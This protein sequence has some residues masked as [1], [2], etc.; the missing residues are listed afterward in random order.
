MKNKISAFIAA[1]TM[2][3]SSVAAMPHATVDA[4]SSLPSRVDLSETEFYPG[5]MDQGEL[6]SCGPCAAVFGQFTYEVRK[7]LREKDP[8]ADISFTYSP[9]SVYS[10]INLGIN[11]PVFAESMYT[12]LM[13][14]GALTEDVF[15]YD[16]NFDALDHIPNDEKA[17]FDALK[18]RVDR[19]E[20]IELNQMYDRKNNKVVEVEKSESDARVRKGIKDIK[21]ALNEGKVLVAQNNYNFEEYIA[22][23]ATRKNKPFNEKVSYQNDF[24]G[25]SHYFT[26]VGYDDEIACDINGDTR[27]DPDTEK[28]AFKIADS[29]GEDRGNNGYMWVMYD[30]LY[31]ES[32]TG[33][34][35]ISY[36][37]NNY[38]YPALMG[39]YEIY[40]SEKDIKLVAEAD[41]KT[42]NY[43]DVYLKNKCRNNGLKNTSYEKEGVLPVEYEGPV[44][45]DIT[46]ICGDSAN[47][48]TFEVTV[49]N[50]NNY[51]YTKVLVKNICLKDD[52]GN[53]VYKKEI[54]SEDEIAKLYNSLGR[55]SYGA[56]TFELDLPVGDINY[57]GVYDKKDYK[58]IKKYYENSGSVDFSLFQQ[59]LIDVDGNQK[60]DESD[61]KVLKKTY[62][63]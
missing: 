23:K 42:N 14:Q 9:L 39:A 35:S 32:L 27:I 26:I 13:K 29:Y 15:P 5:I 31:R 44:M 54:C 24:L 37:G 48:K 33:L 50:K 2:I 57:D 61:Y 63:K 59:E 56:A 8:D 53:I 45:A 28:G 36:D 47:N 60:F 40:V 46:E 1:L 11:D 51:G 34:N 22:D 21:K 41:I 18:I 19:V 62:K 3:T 25:C 38:R 7:Y 52:K 30:A 17:L 58:I 20:S 55:G 49:K 43:Y 16:G 4:A 6:N 10:S 12:Y